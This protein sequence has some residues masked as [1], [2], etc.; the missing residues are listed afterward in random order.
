V[1]AEENVG[2]AAGHVGGNGDGAL[3]PRL[4]NNLRF[5][6]V[7]L[8]VQ[9][10]VRNSRLLQQLGDLFRFFDGDAAH[11]DRLAA[12]VILPDAAR[13]RAV[14]LNYPVH[15]GIELFAFG[16]VNDVGI[17]DADQRLVRR[18][19]DDFELVDL[20]ELRRFG[21]RG[22]GHAGK[23]LVHAEII[24]EGNGG[25]SLVLALD[26]HAFLRFHCL[27]QTVG[28]APARHLASREFVD[29]HHFAFFHDI[30]DIALEERVR[31]Q[32]LIDVM[33]DVH[34]GGVEEI[35]EIEQTLAF[36]DA[37]FGERR[38]ALLFVE[39]VIDFLDELGDYF[40][41][42]V[43]LVGGFFGRTG[44]NQRRASLVDQDRVHFVDD[45]EL[46]AALNAILQVVL[47]VVTQVIES[48]FVVSAE[49]DVGAIGGAALRV[50]EIVNDHAHAHAEDLVDGAHP[51]GV[52]AGEI[53][54]HGD[55]VNAF[56][57]ER[58]QVGG[59]GGDERFSLAR[60][61]FRDFALM[62][63]DAA[64]ELHV[65]V[66]HADGSAACLADQGER[67][68]KR[69]LERVLELLLVIWI[70]ALEAFEAGL[71]FGTQR[72]SA[73]AD[74]G[75]GELLHGRLE[76]VDL[77]D[78]RRDFL[79]VALVLR[80]DEARNYPVD[81]FFDIKCHVFWCRRSLARRS[82][83][84]LRDNSCKTSTSIV[85]ARAFS[86]KAAIR[87]GR[88][89]NYCQFRTLVRRRSKFV[90]PVHNFVL[91]RGLGPKRETARA[92]SQKTRPAT[93]KQ[94]I[95]ESLSFQ[96]IW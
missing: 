76:L 28:P 62:Q 73:L 80:P 55:D 71:H 39:R 40:V 66:A 22:S 56:V 12:L 23:L 89:S 69:R 43:I 88:F 9:H 53:V 51:L 14:F 50:V 7:V 44:N 11:Q 48:E 27:M 29:D 13:A 16:A 81:R 8:G 26:L 64:D 57:S 58:V 95:H 63:D 60:L 21:F 90:E 91:V 79:D 75:V 93:T 77:D 70:G 45:S 3:A 10:L 1:A 94:A 85:A 54:V 86:R 17:L 42:A 41:D 15:R 84:R 49:G 33:N 67:G 31:A 46:V 30:I 83:A 47:H 2:S 35:A 38:G 19:G 6:L 34:V 74:F 78:V 61:H 52:A 72:D 37:F 68:N 82:Q 18:D 96:V 65:E 5:A 36:R 20:V 92:T 25:E 24:L 4:R 87:R 32:S 59:Q